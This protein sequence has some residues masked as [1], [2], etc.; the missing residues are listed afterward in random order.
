MLPS[1]ARAPAL[2]ARVDWLAGPMAVLI[3]SDRSPA[4]SRRSARAHRVTRPSERPVEVGA[5][6]GGSHAC[7]C[8]GH[9]LSGSLCL[10]PVA[11]PPGSRISDAQACV[12]R[13]HVGRRRRAAI[14]HRRQCRRVARSRGGRQ[15]TAGERRGRIHI[16]LRPVVRDRS[17]GRRRAGRPEHSH[18][19]WHGRRDC[20]L[21]RRQAPGGDIGPRRRALEHR[22]RKGTAPL[23]GAALVVSGQ[24]AD[25]PRGV[26]LWR[27]ADWTEEFEL[28]GAGR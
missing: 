5:S 14:G 17:M 9:A 21:A 23:A 7:C 2:R 22:P 28:V 24:P 1:P 20:V 12:V 6:A 16:G 18:A 26:R 8:A 3:A 25:G 10:R 11:A 13:G 27:T 15:S 4:R 19:R